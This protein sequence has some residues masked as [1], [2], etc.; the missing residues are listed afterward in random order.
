[1]MASGMQK[2]AQE[3]KQ[4]EVIKGEKNGK[5]PGDKQLITILTGYSDAILESM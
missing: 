2:F 5:C 1:M 4:K 3:I